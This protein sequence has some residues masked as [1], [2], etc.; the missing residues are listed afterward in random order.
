ML[1][2]PEFRERYSRMADDEL[3]RI[4]L[5]S[6]LVPEAQKTLKEELQKRGLSDLSKYEAAL[7]QAAEE[8]SLGRQMELQVRMERQI[9][10]WMFTSWD[11]SLR[12]LCLLCG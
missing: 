2:E 1:Q 10:E 8:R 4:A 6:E 5:E 12:H 9:A 3:A 7:K 11:G